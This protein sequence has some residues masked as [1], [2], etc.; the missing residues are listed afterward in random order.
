MKHWIV[1]ATLMVAMMLFGGCSVVEQIAEYNLD[2]LDTVEEEQT[3][4]TIKLPESN[5]I[6]EQVELSMYNPHTLNPLEGI[7]YS[8]DQALRLVY[9]PLYSINDTYE[10]VP[11]IATSLGEAEGLNMTISLDPSHTFSNGVAL[12][13]DDVVYSYAFI[14]NAPNS[15]YKY[16]T[17]YISQISAV[18]ANTIRVS[19]AQTNRFN[20]YALTFPIISKSYVESDA[21]DP[22]QPV[23]SGK[24]Y[25][26]DMQRMLYMTLAKR[27][28]GVDIEGPPKIQFNICRRFE[29]S[30]NMFSSKRVDIFAPEATHWDRYSDDLRITTIDYDS[31]YYYSILFNTK[32]NYFSSLDTRRYIASLIDYERVK[33]Q[34][35]LDHVHVQSLPIYKDN[36]LKELGN[37]YT[38]ENGVGSYYASLYNV[39]KAQLYKPTQAEGEAPILKGIYNEEDYYQVALVKE[40]ADTFSKAMIPIDWIPYRESEYRSALEGGDFD[41]ACQVYQ[42]SI[43]PR[44]DKWLQSGG[45][46]NY[47]GYGSIG[48]DGLVSDFAQVSSDDQWLAKTEALSRLITEELPYIPL[49]Q[50]ENGLFIH[51]QVVGQLSPSYYRIYNGMEEIKF[52]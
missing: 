22:M 35:F 21:Y 18:D 36:T 49:G 4:E 39:D 33:S 13:A 50:L 29:D 7:S 2:H 5:Y 17:E 46:L 30:Y 32:R 52:K 25:L 19:F 10:L 38:L 3:D 51:D 8:V 43:V 1:M 42:M 23:G 28:D 26:K 6:K 20:A 47:G 16:V 15:G 40:L 24:Y 11:Q 45:A 48:M 37:P 44:M 27:E 31:P 41:L 12:T 34:V 9:E 14:K